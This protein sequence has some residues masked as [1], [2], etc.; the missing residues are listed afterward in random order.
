[1]CHLFCLCR[2]YQRF[3]PIQEQEST[4]EGRVALYNGI[5]RAARD[6]TALTFTTVHNT[7]TNGLSP[8][9]RISPQFLNVFK[10]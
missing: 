1:M 3:I 8:Q 5:C 9:P 7:R 4:I 6:Q 10:E 2:E